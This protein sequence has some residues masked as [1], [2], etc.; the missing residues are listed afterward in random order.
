[1]D[2]QNGN[3]QS[4]QFVQVKSATK[5]VVAGVL[6]KLKI[7]IKVNGVQKTCDYEVWDRSWLPEGKEVKVQCEG[8][9]EQK[10][11]RYRRSEQHIIGGDDHDIH[12]GLF[13]YFTYKFNKTY[14][15]KP[16]YKRRFR[17]FRSNMK[18]IQKLNEGEQGTATYGPTVF[19]DM[20]PEEYKRHLGLKP[21]L[22]NPN[23]IPYPQAVIPDIELPKEF[24]W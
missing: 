12:M 9:T 3:T 22:Y 17:I 16:E 7:D 15:N 24:D 2:S 19:A 5:Q 14:A 18:I 10:N 13:K 11:Y 1:M 8:D 20:T 6:Y 4:T 23:N 21:E